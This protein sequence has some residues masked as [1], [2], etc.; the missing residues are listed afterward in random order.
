[1]SKKYSAAIKLKSKLLAVHL[2]DTYS[3]VLLSWALCK[4]QPEKNIIHREDEI[5]LILIIFLYYQI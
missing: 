1:M 4:I 3:K 5:I 2:L